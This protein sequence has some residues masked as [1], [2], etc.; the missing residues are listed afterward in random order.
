MKETKHTEALEFWGIYKNS[1]NSII[2]VM[3]MFS[4]QCTIEELEKLVEHPNKPG[5]KRSDILKRI[6]ELRQNER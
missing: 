2:D 1:K 3:V 6:K 4:K 5:Y